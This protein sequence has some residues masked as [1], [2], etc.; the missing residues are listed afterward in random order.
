MISNQSFTPAGCNFWHKD[1]LACNNKYF[2][3]SSNT[4]IYIFNIETLRCEKILSFSDSNIMMV[5]WP[6]TSANK[7]LVLSTAKKAFFCDTNLENFTLFLEFEN[8]ILAADWGSQNE[9]LVALSFSS[10]NFS[11]FSLLESK[12]PKGVVRIHDLN[13][14]KIEKNYDLMFSVAKC[15]K[16]NKQKVIITRTLTLSFLG[17]SHCFGL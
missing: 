7:M 16:W 17:K 6:Q 13:T 11:F 5:L 9:N 10:S 8:Q 1:V 2:S 14:K 4:T 3:Y 12:L 15:V